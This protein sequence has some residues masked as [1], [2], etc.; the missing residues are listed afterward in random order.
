MTEKS[1]WSCILWDM[2][3]TI[4]DASEGILE[5]LEVT[6][7]HLGKPAPTRDDLIDWIGPPMRESFERN[8]NLTLD[9]AHEA[10]AHYRSLH[11]YNNMGAGARVYDGVTELIGEVA[12]AGVPQAIASSK[13]E[14]QVVPLANHFAI[15]DDFVTMVGASSDGVTRGTKADVVREALKR[16]ADAGVDTSRPVLIGDRHH[17]IEGGA[18]CGVPVIHVTWGFS[19]PNEGEGSIATATTATEL[20]ALLLTA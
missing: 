4:V 12:A 19:H 16:L 3:G 7:A 13:P 20:R 15:S 10:V 1:Q 17:D 18:E 6:F 11:D 14:N 9:E 2:D 5:R 8:A